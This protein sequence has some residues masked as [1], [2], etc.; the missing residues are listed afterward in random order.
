MYGQGPADIYSF[1]FLFPVARYGTVP[2]EAIQDPHPPK[3]ILSTCFGCDCELVP[4][5]TRAVPEGVSP[6]GRYRYVLTL[7]SR[8][9][10]RDFQSRCR[11]SYS[12]G[13]A[14]VRMTSA[15]CATCTSM[16]P[17]TPVRVVHNDQS[18]C[19][20]TFGQRYIYAFIINNSRKA[21]I[22]LHWTLTSSACSVAEASGEA[23]RWNV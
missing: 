14:S 4:E 23:G 18:A 6:T 3:P 1:W 17:C 16:I 7:A 8:E 13:A 20:Q 12:A 2:L 21:R 19:V 10:E 15:E 5:T 9:A 11:S 22:F